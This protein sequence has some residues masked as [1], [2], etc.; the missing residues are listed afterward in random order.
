MGAGR[1]AERGGVG[2]YRAWSNVS[3]VCP[4]ASWAAGAAPTDLAGGTARSFIA[5]PFAFIWIRA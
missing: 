5:F 2:A 3:T 4:G 1:Q